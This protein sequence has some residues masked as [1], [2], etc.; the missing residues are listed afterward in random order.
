MKLWSSSFT[1]ADPPPLDR[2]REA[3]QRIS[4]ARPALS[5]H[6][7]GVIAVDGRCYMFRFPGRSMRVPCAGTLTGEGASR[8]GGSEPICLDRLEW[9]GS[10]Y[11]ACGGHSERCQTD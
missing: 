7:N 8:P 10:A 1:E 2:A 11:V 5:T 9:Q 3:C 4:E 6:H